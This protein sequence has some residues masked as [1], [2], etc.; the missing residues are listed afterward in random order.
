MASTKLKNFRLP[1]DL[2]KLLEED[3]RTQT[4]VVVEALRAEYAAEEKVSQDWDKVTGL[5]L[6][7]RVAQLSNT[8]PPATA[9]R[10]AELEAS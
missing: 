7:E 1:L 5:G 9:Q 8:L 6:S 2:C 4:E 10:I 3:E